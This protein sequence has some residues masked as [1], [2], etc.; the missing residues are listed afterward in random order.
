MSTSHVVLQAIL[1][2]TVERFPEKV[3]IR[4]N[5]QTITY[6]EL[7]RLSS[8]FANALVGLGVNK[9]DRVAV[10]LGNC[11]QFVIAYFG[12]LKAGAA[13]TAVS[14]LHK[15]LEVERQL[16]DSGAQVIVVLESLYSVVEKIMGETLLQRVIVVGDDG[17]GECFKVSGVGVGSNVFDFWGLIEKSAADLLDFRSISDGDLAV[18]QYTS[19]TAGVPKGVMLSH[20][21]LASNVLS[22]ASWI[23]G[24]FKDVFLSVLPL[25]HVYGMMTSMLVPISL[26]AEIVLLPQFDPVECLRIIGRCG[27][28]VFCGSPFMF[29]ILLGAGFERYDLLSI[30]VCIS[31]ASRLPCHVQERFMR[32]GVFL[33]EGYGLTEASPVTHCTPIDR[34]IGS[35]KMGSVGLALPGTEAR[36]VDVE[37][38]DRVVAV[39]EWGELCV[40]GLQVMWGYW[41]NSVETERVLRD[42]WLFT[43]DIVY[44]DSDGYVYIVGRKKGIIKCK[45]YSICPGELEAVLYG[46]PAV[47]FCVVI[48]KPDRLYGEVPKA[49][50]VLREGFEVV[51]DELIEF[52]NG[53]IAGY[54]ALVEVEICNELPYGSLKGKC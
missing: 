41:H 31:G 18:L 40:R 14:P 23:K 20:I 33:V 53:K 36:V 12:V 10:F 24:T 54:K 45:G 4:Y 17:G 13:V 43:G 9:G 1:S 7:D 16:C 21:N 15:E 2:K 52:V 51:S 8:R 30:R 49:F 28:S 19:G 26:G 34:L 5:N 46:H 48:G 38:G 44:M 42:G 6:G 47:K 11:P 27:V 3:V 50:V 35:V 25:Y 37:T 29:S 32:A 22:F 39:G